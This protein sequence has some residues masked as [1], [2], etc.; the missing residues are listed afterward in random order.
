M[1]FTAWLLREIKNQTGNACLR[2]VSK[3][4]YIKNC[5]KEANLD[6][7]LWKLMKHID[8]EEPTSFLDHVYLGCIQP[9]CTTNDCIVDENKEMFKSR[10][11]EKL[12]GWETSHASTIAWS[13]DMEGDAKKCV[14]RSGICW[15]NVKSM[16]S[17]LSWDAC[18]C[19]RLVFWWSVNKFARAIT[20]WTAACDKRLARLISFIHHTSEFKQPCLVGNSAQQCR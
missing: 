15:R 8:L 17:K 3:V 20:K 19:G 7:M 12:L 10:A 9:G 16:H 11:S 14:R 4:Y 18:V 6:H 13:H 2:I 1:L 5:W